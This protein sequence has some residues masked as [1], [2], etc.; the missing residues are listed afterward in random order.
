[1][2]M[3]NG[4]KAPDEIKSIKD[5]AWSKACFV[6]LFALIPSIMNG[7]YIDA[8]AF[9]MPAFETCLGFILQL[10]VAFIIG[11]AMGIFFNDERDFRKLIIVGLTAPGLIIALMNGNV[12]NRSANDLNSIQKLYNQAMLENVELKQ[13]L[14]AIGSPT[15]FYGGIVLAQAQTTS[16]ITVKDFSSPKNNSANQFWSGFTGSNSQ[17]IWF[18]IAGSHLK[19]EDAERQAAAIN[20]EG[21]F[22]AEVYAPYGQNPYYAVVIGANL[23][24]NVAKDFRNKA[25]RAGLPKDTYLWALPTD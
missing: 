12:M 8:H 4:E 21:K 9:K 1:M 23:T 5:I 13:K 7:F 16:G 20:H 11:F 14:K 6:G 18:V 25:I 17:N 10:I 3:S 22:R 19:R 2:V 15:A 24:L